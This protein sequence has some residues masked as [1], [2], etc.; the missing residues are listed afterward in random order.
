MYNERQNILVF[1]GIYIIALAIYWILPI[2]TTKTFL[3]YTILLFSLI[4]AVAGGLYALKK[5]GTLGP[6]APTIILL[7][8][9]MGSWLIGESLWTY[10]E[11]IANIQPFPSIADIFY[12]LAY[13]MFFYALYREI[14]LT[15]ISWKSL[16]TSLLFLMGII[17][18]LLIIIVSYFG[19][20]MAYSPNETFLANT[21]AISYGVADMIL[22]IATMALLVLAW[23]FR[24]GA[25]SRIWM[26]IFISF[27]LTLVA[28][29]LFA[30]FTNSYGE[31][32][33]I[34]RNLTDSL[35][36]LAY[37]LFA[38]A[39]FDFGL[40]IETAKIHLE[41]LI[42]KKESLAKITEKNPV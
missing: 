25:L 10:F 9:G 34:Q 7:T 3:Q 29:I 6:K 26:S 13:P 28:D 15:Q 2:S 31:I 41:S 18:L 21:I 32:G 24:G 22:I 39:M 14:K 17:A 35:W 38:H 42:S 36:I 27:F 23:E 37:L 12:L 5:Y 33:S 20:Y 4:T 19:V 30:I 16:S 8:F 40:S 1:C 11:S